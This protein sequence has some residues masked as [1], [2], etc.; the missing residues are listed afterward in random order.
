MQL[1]EFDNLYP[2]TLRKHTSE[3][4]GL[5]VD[6]YGEVMREAGRADGMALHAVL[7]CQAVQVKIKG[8]RQKIREIVEEITKGCGHLPANL[9]DF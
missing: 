8:V 4:R 3:T 1:A 9:L 6:A 7:G 2:A 5:L